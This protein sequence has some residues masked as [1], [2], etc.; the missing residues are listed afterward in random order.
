MNTLFTYMLG[1]K[2]PKVRFLKQIAEG[3][4][5]EF[6]DFQE[7]IYYQNAFDAEQKNLQQCIWSPH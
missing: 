3:I 4:R 7:N 6:P 2:K 5:Q 1:V